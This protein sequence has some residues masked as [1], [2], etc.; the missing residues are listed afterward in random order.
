ML[1]Y[2]MGNCQICPYLMPNKFDI[3]TD[4]NALKWLKSMRIGSAL[5]SWSAVLEGFNFTIHHRPGKHQGHVDELSH[6]PVKD[7]PPDGEEA[8]LLVQTLSSEEATQ[9]AAQEL[10]RA[11]HV[12]GD[13]LWK[14]FW[15]R[16]SYTRG[17]RI[18]LE[19][20]RS[21]IQCQAGTD[22]GATWKTAGTIISIGPWDTLSVDI[23]GPLPAYRRMENII[24][25]VDCPSKCAILIPSKDHTA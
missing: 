2:Y 17:K 22:Y 15:D 13:A 21:C 23:V 5:H 10:H 19:V 11:T 4:H 25:L 20:A 14:L 7:A 8:S 6:L 1:S 9:Q 12:G 3:Y 18:C 16:F 24:T